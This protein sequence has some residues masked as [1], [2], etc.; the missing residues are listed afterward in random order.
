VR[1]PLSTTLAMLA[2]RS[3]TLASHGWPGTCRPQRLRRCGYRGRPGKVKA[4]LALGD[5]FHVHGLAVRAEDLEGHLRRL[6]CNRVVYAQD[7][8]G[9]KVAVLDRLAVRVLLVCSE[10]VAGHAVG[11]V[12]AAHEPSAGVKPGGSSVLACEYVYV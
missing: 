9:E 7:L 5:R 11:P 3:I 2:I 12:A 1:L 6:A 4:Q 8:V 10:A